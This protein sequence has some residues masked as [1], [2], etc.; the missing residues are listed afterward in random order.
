MHVISTRVRLLLHLWLTR[1]CH[2]RQVSLAM[3]LEEAGAH[4][5]QT[6]VRTFFVKHSNEIDAGPPLTSRI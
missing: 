5:I 3:A 6:E 4:V 1:A 2:T